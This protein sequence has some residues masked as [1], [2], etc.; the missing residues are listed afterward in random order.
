MIQKLQKKLILICTASVF[1]VAALIFSII[2]ILNIISINRNID[3][4]AD[5]VAEGGGTF[6]GYFDGV[7][8]PDQLPPQSDSE[9]DYITPETPFA[10]RHFTV[11]FDSDGKVI[12]T[13][14]ES[15]YSINE[16]NAIEYARRVVNGR[17]AK[18]WI[19]SYRY[20]IYENELGCYVVFVDGSM[21][22]AVFMQ[23]TMSAGL[24]LTIC[25]L[26]VI[27]L[28]TLL[29]KKAVAPIAESYEKQKQFIT[30][31]NHELKTPLTLILANVDIAETEL[32]ENEWLDDIRTEGI[33]MSDL[34][35]QL[36]SL[37]RMDEDGHALNVSRVD[38]D[39]IV[40]EAVNKFSPLAK[41]M[42]KSIIYKNGG[43][44]IYSGD[45][46][47]LRRLVD[48]LLDNAVKYCDD[49]GEIKISLYRTKR[50]ILT[51]ENT[52]AG[53]NELELNRLFDRFYRA[54]KARTYTGGYG[55]GL[56]LAKAIVE[57]HKGEI[58]VHKKDN[59][60]I[61]FKVTL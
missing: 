14:T 4:L 35:N 24:V 19:S 41:E 53:I 48:I 5:R 20:K 7:F 52:Y 6:P 45:A 32:G 30:N 33:R 21:N 9:F 56:S 25:A 8:S 3:T 47:L 12:K 26:L 11:F 1:S 51:V 39:G 29:S 40:S 55:V 50:V 13:N 23:S 27:V 34:V 15:I 59:R 28:I 36:T 42:K 16:K 2:L 22:R 31:V 17:K 44:V 54:D 18:G 58:S 38:L 46:A 37:S 10:T 49:D 57:N 60:S 43:S 61:I